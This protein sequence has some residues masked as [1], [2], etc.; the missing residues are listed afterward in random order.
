MLS[1]DALRRNASTINWQAVECRPRS[2]DNNTQ[3]KNSK[4]NAPLKCCWNY[5]KNINKYF[6]LVLFITIGL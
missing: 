3:T 4:H 5:T 2:C 1:M 6:I